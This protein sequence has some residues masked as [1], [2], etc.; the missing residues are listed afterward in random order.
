[1]ASP[2]LRRA[3][4]YASWGLNNRLL[5]LVEFF[6]ARRLTFWSTV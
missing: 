2:L 5:S 3:W 6:P 4:N 1:L